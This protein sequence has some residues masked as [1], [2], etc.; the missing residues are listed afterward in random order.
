MS[1]FSENQGLK[2]IRVTV[3]L[4]VQI[5]LGPY[6]QSGRK[7]I[8]HMHIQT[9]ETTILTLVAMPVEGYSKKTI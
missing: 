9:H 2:K 3:N 1:M 8:I 5:Y 7:L 4:Y 6:V